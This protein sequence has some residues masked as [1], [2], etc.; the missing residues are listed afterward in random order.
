MF[1]SDTIQP[2]YEDN[3]LL[4]I[5]KPAGLLSQGDN[6]GDTALIDLAKDYIKVQY[7]K[8]GKVFLGLCHRLDRPVSGV[9]LMARTSKAL[10]R[11][12][13]LFQ[14]A[15]I[16][17]TYWA[18]SQNRPR[19]DEGRLEQWLLKDTTKNMVAIVDGPEKD[20]KLAITHYRLIATFEQYH[21]IELKPETGRSHQLR[22]A[23][24]TLK[25]SILG[26]LKY[27]GSAFDPRSIGLHCRMLEFVH[28]VTKETIKITAPPPD[29]EPWVYF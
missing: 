25:A 21:L 22:V 16:K 10:E 27:G 4:A 17:K 19:S 26:D 8:P 29:A 9:L 5:N 20:A 23:M 2:L 24:Q 18:I 14:E 6:T 3:H 13:R 1:D 15:Q 28:P 12:N 11:I 7:H